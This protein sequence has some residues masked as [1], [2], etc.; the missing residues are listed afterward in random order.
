[1]NQG[2]PHRPL[3]QD[4]RQ[5][6]ADRGHNSWTCAKENVG[7]KTELSIKTHVPWARTTDV[8]RRRPTILGGGRTEPVPAKAIRQCNGIADE[9]NL[10][11]L[12][13]SDNVTELHA[14]NVECIE[15][16]YS[17]NLMSGQKRV[18]F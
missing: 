6:L 11:L 18:F 12:E 17:K 14:E 10:C 7:L 16:D 4:R 15:A 8:A 3:H 2:A 13:L 1:M 5:D 9:L